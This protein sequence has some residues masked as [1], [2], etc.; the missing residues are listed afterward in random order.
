MEL[1]DEKTRGRKSRDR[2]PLINKCSINDFLREDR[3]FFNHNSK[4]FSVDKIDSLP[5]I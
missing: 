3:V 1:F 2:V 5:C 4:K